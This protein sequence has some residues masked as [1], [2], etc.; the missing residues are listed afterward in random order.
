MAQ[1]TERPSTD[2]PNTRLRPCPICGRPASD[3]QEPFCS[4]RC[5][6][7]DLHRWFGGVYRVPTDE[8]DD[9]DPVSGE[10]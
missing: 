10:E 7:V 4:P 5:A 9:A 2:V 1:D 6:E 3:A 8:G